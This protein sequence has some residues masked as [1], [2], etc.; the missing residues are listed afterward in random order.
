MP[1]YFV[2]VIHRDSS[3]VNH[4]RMTVNLSRTTNEEDG[5]NKGRLFQFTGTTR[6]GASGIYY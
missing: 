5:Q 4:C 6:R 2:D 1:S 3:W